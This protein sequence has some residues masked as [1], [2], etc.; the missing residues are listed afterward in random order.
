MQTIFSCGRDVVGGVSNQGTFGHCTYFAN[1]DALSIILRMNNSIPNDVYLSAQCPID[2]RSGK[3]PSIMRG[4]CETHGFEATYDRPFVGFSKNEYSESP[5][6]TR[7]RVE[8]YTIFTDFEKEIVHHF[9]DGSGFPCVAS[10]SGTALM[11]NPPNN[12][13]SSHAVVVY[14][15]DVSDPHDQRCLIKNSWG[16]GWANC[17]FSDIPFK[18]IKAASVPKKIVYH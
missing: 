18:I 7:F 15:V 5:G 12:L 9:K 3:K 11:V 2:F 8:G 4:F 14:C 17:G 16:K 6:V 10:I 13:H 1:A